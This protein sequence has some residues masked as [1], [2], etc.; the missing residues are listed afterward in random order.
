MIGKFIVAVLTSEINTAAFHLNSDD[1]DRRIVMRAAGLLID[2]DSADFNAHSVVKL[3]RIWELW[4]RR[5]VTAG[6]RRPTAL[7][8]GNAFT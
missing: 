8:A 4:R 3:R 7:V 2:A 5:R 6:F 1:V